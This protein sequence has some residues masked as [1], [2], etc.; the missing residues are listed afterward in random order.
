M[1]LESGRL[2]LCI[3]ANIYIFRRM[4]KIVGVVA[5]YVIRAGRERGFSHV[6]KIRMKLSTH[7][8]EIRYTLRINAG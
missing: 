4:N 8:R 3:P 6:K 7:A 1:L 5:T 2:L